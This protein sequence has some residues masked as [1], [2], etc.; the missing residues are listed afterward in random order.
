[1]MSTWHFLKAQHWK[2]KWFAAKSQV[3][4]GGEHLA[5]G[6]LKQHALPIVA[7]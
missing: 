6:H 3:V 1:M 2:R 7:S 5:S 4:M